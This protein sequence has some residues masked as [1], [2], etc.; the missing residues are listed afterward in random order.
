MTDRFRSVGEN[1][2]DALLGDAPEW[3]DDLGDHRFS[4]RLTDH[5]AEADARRAGVLTDA[6]GALDEIDD[7]LLPAADRVD[8]EMLRNRVS[9]DLWQLTELRPQAWD[10]L[11]HLPGDALYGLIAAEDL[12]AD[13]RLRAIAARCAAVPE[14]LATAR[15]RLD[16]GP[17]MP[18]VH[19]QTAIG[20][21]EGV[22]GLLGS[23]VDPL[24]AQVPS[25]RST[26]DDARETAAAA[27]RE[28]I[29]WL[30]SR[31]ETADADP[32][33]GARDHAARLWYT[34]DSELSQDALLTR[35]ESD[36]LATEEAI[37]ETASDFAGAPPRP[38]Q[39]REVLDRI[40]AEGAT[41]EQTVRPTCEQA[42]EHLAGRVRDLDFATLPDH[43]VRVIPMPESRRGM[44]V[45]YCDPP[46]PLSPRPERPTLIAVAPPPA[47]W[48]AARRES[49]Y[50]EYNADML[51]E[52]MVHEGV[53]G[54]ALQLSHAARYS[55]GTRL[56]RALLSGT[57]IEGWAVYAEEALQEDGWCAD[58]PD[59]NRRLRLV[60]LKTRLRMIINAILDVRVHAHGMTES[61]AMSL[62]VERG[63]Q[64]EGEAAGKWRRAQLSSAQLATYYV[65]DQEVSAI[66][67]DLA[68]ALPGA[69]RRTVHD[70][71]LAHGSPPPRHLR[72]LLGI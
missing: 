41:A 55:G 66:V 40:A 54:H 4:D 46:G 68:A 42:L 32:R 22:L 65:G 29:G 2:L 39:V 12:P 59:R 31:A 48:P 36:L 3:A 47:D 8:L 63:H 5:S 57:F 24:V 72:T 52:L 28:H 25:L 51:R 49:F 23:G 11:V 19:V 64:E 21:A 69:P 34:L 45:A 33:L 71:V 18:R 27:L 9:A 38:G 67:R 17:G 6:L 44:S 70:S 62:L 20:W 50:R 7:L 26:A 35:A 43:P 16:G 53:P 1:I 60:Q 37:A 58:D 61:E 14:F 15:S 56:R 13:E 30:R 10:P